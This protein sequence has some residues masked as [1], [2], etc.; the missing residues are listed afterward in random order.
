MRN[1]L[2]GILDFIKVIIQALVV[3]AL[4]ITLLWLPNPSIPGVHGIRKFLLDM[5][6]TFLFFELVK[7]IYRAG[8]KKASSDAL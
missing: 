2:K 5:L 6:G 4:I 3:I 8:N 7:L 1:F